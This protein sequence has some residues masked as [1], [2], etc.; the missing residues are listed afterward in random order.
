M[1]TTRDRLLDAVRE[2]AFEGSLDDLTPSSIARRA[3][4]HRVTF[5]RFFADLQDAVMQAFT[6]EIDRLSSVDDERVAGV[7]SVE[8]LARIYG[9]TLEES[10][11]DIRDHR[12]VYRSLFATPAFQSHV[13]GV[14]RGRA[15]TMVTTLERAGIPVPG[16]ESGTAADFVGGASLSVL[17][18]WAAD[19]RTDVA[20]RA[21]EIIDQM[22]AWWPRAG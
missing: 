15:A 1:T 9:G 4:T 12:A 18:A 6:A 22:P 14:L 17:S 13:L 3:G 10:L 20:A 21:A 7:T 16:A 19:E 11:V 2:S 8:A 5:Y